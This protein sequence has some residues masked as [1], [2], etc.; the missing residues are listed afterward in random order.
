MREWNDL[1]VKTSYREQLAWKTIKPFDGRKIHLI[2]IRVAWL[3][4]RLDPF[5]IYRRLS[6]PSGN[7][8]R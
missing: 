1:T 4:S 6:S 3:A 5:G 8:W 2:A 7:F